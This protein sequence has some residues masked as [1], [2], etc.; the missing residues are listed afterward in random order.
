VNAWLANL[1]T[2]AGF[3][4][5]CDSSWPRAV[6]LADDLN[7]SVKY[8]QAYAPDRTLEKRASPFPSAKTKKAS[9]PKEKKPKKVGA[10][11]AF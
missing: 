4:F 8:N 5:N 1:P 10:L 6:R 2:V 7:G 11:D 9:K 3:P